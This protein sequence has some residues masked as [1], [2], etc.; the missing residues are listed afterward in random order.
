MIGAIADDFTGGTDVAVALRQGGLRT[1]IYFGAPDPV[2]SLPEHDAIVIAL[3]TRTLAPADAV[4]QSMAAAEWLLAH[5]ARQL[6]FKYC[7][8]FDSKPEGNIGPVADALAAL[9]GSHVTVAVPSSPEHL[10]TQYMGHLF[11][12]RQRL[13]E[14]P[15]RHHPLTPM[16]DSSVPRLLQAQ[17][18]ARVE[19]L[20]LRD[21]RSGSIHLRQRLDALAVADT[22]SYAVIDALTEDDLIE[23]GRACIHDPLL[24]GA[25]GLAR[26]LAAA[27]SETP[28]ATLAELE[29]TAELLPAPGAAAVLAGSCS[30]RTLQQIA[31]LQSHGHPSFQLDALHTQNPHALADDALRWFDELDTVKEPLFYSSLP[32]E[33]LRAVQD[34]LGTGTASDILETAMGLIAVGLRARGT[35]RVIVAGG[36]TSGAVVTSLGIQGALIGAE[37][38][39][40][41]PWIHTVDETPISL[42]L[43]SGNFGDVGF[44]AEALE[45][46]VVAR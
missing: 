20:D 31:V 36:E 45:Q 18:D 41:V 7:S 1:L 10:R 39:P 24:T 46:D 30:A 15:L 21:V 29:L 9:V 5:G 6:F 38:A 3:K 17:T 23:I 13:D 8:T 43:K 35:A 2:V 42:L 44:L 27:T 26:G 28:T 37:I 11:V 32:P 4:T 22:R 34:A 16:T 14:S 19:L 25:A 12:D 40:G 33:Q